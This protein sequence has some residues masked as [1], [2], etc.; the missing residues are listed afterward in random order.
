MLRP[1]SLLACFAVL[2]CGGGVAVDPDGGTASDAGRDA[3]SSDDAGALDAGEPPDAA[4]IDDAG[5]DAG[6]GGDD[7]GAQCECLDETLRWELDGGLRLWE[8]TNEIVPCRTY[9][10]TRT[11]RTGPST[12]CT[13]EVPCAEDAITI[14]ELRAA[15]AHPDVVAAFAAAP[16]LYGRDGRAFD[17]PLFVVTQGASAVSIGL[18]CMAGGGACTPIPPG[19]AALRDLLTTLEGERLAEGDCATTFP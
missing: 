17:A 11:P 19:V 10:H 2:G 12:S 15:L 13:N 18:P 6:G 5:A 16:V 9:E 14:S 1:V 3:G 4:A 7:A 8:A